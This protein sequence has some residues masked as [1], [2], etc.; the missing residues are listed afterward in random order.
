MLAVLVLL[1]V[2]GAAAGVLVF[3]S[4]DTTQ[5]A[6][7]FV[8]GDNALFFSESCLEESFVQI[9][10]NPDYAEKNFQ[11]P[12]GDCE[13]NIE[14]NNTAYVIHAIGKISDSKYQ[15]GVV[16]EVSLDGTKLNVVSWKEE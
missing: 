6:Q 10:R 8:D 2:T 16:V 13:I 1:V 3:A 4:I 11:L 14:K 5:S 15:H 7:A 9:I 12:D